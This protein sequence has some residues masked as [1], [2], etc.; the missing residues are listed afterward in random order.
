MSE[1]KALGHQKKYIF[2]VL[3][4]QKSRYID[5]VYSY[6]YSEELAV[7]TVVQVP[8]GRGNK[9]YRGIVVGTEEEGRREGL[10]EILGVVD[11]PPHLSPERLRLADWIC[12]EYLSSHI[13]AITLFYPQS[14]REAA[15]KYRRRIVV[16]DKASLCEAFHRLPKNATKKKKLYQS[17]LEGEEIYEESLRSEI[18]AFPRQ[19]LA[20]LAEKRILHI[21]EERDCRSPFAGK[22]EQS[23]EEIS[24]N[25]MQERVYEEILGEIGQGNRPMLLRGITGSG[26][27]Q[28][29]IRLMEHMLHQGKGVIVLV[30]EISLTPQ[31]VERFRQVCGE[32]LA[33]IHSNLS[34]REKADEWKRIQEMDAP[35]VI[36]ARSALFA[37]VRNPGLLIIDECHDDAYQSEQSPK[38]QATELAERMN[39][40]LG[41]CLLLGSATP[42]ISQY[43]K[44]KIGE[45]KLLE[46]TERA[47][48][49]PLPG[50][51][52]VN[53]LDDAKD[54]NLS[55]LSNKLQRYMEEELAKDNQVIL[56]I[57]RRGYA[58]FVTCR[59]CG[60][61]PRCAHCDISLT[62]H[63]SKNVLR[64]H[65][66]NYEQPFVRD[67]PSCGE[68]HLEDRGMGTERI[69][70]EVE[71]F[72]PQAEI[73]RMDRD[74]VKKRGDHER[75][76]SAF[77]HSAKGVLIGTQMI[78]KGH[79][80]PRV[81]LVGIIHADQGMYFPDYRS[82]ERTFNSIEQVGGRAGRGEDEGR[83]VIQTFSPHH[84]MLRHVKEHD[85][86]A[87]Y[88]EEIRL[89]E[90]YVYPPYGNLL[91][92]LV[93]GKDEIRTASS[94]MKIRDAF[95]FY[96]QKRELLTEEVYGPYPCM[97]S[98]AEDKY[99]WQILLKD[100]QIPLDRIK[101]ILN[102]ILTEKR[103]IVLEKEVYATI[104]INPV[105]MA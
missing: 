61:I 34:K 38:Y 44:A 48:Q 91:R 54:G 99:R 21:H 75:I 62:Y 31:T 4:D 87:F 67:C 101:K 40:E 25:P 89:R 77:R 1:E 3:L 90:A 5:R 7:G 20:E 12:R 29:Y 83:V 33:L 88:E 10:K 47:N 24:L 70:Q 76:L 11:T 43:H 8:F 50:V 92:V 16:E 58:G 100:R 72:F 15:P 104:D 36:G 37:P 103:G 66:C 94:A 68:G 97:I 64:C 59:S 85:Y 52:I 82:N 41:V 53:M 26:K 79:D 49:K 95:C 55:F 80:F 56:Y 42:K 74:S 45:W 78:G 23:R 17:L 86:K 63:K 13:D 69:V 9:V 96:A 81:N 98:K 30:P 32:R 57:N 39:L 19:Y 102:Y 22:Q 14:I 65:Y 28:V 2:Q 84:H 18:G 35:V 27:T 105:N 71:E 46:L 60:H 51:E 93:V 6:E 73:Y